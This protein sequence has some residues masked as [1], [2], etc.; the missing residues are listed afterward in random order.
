MRHATSLLAAGIALAGSFLSQSASGQVTSILYTLPAFT[1]VL[2]VQKSDNALTVFQDRLDI[3]LRS[4]F[5]AFFSDQL[6]TEDFSY[7]T[8]VDV[9]LVSQTFW[10]EINDDGETVE[11]SATTAT[12]DPTAPRRYEVRASFESQMEVIMDMDI[13]STK[14]PQ[15]SMDLLFVEALQGDNYWDL[16]ELFVSD[17]EL[18]QINTVEISVMANGFRPFDSQDGSVTGYDTE[19]YWTP[20][21]TVGVAFAVFFVCVLAIM[22]LYLCIFVRG[23]C[24]FRTRR[25]LD[26]H[27]MMDHK[28][29]PEQSSDTDQNSSD[30]EGDLAFGAGPASESAWMDA[31]ATA[32]T[33]IPVRELA[34]G[35]KKRPKK[36]RVRRPSKQ[37]C[38]NL[39]QIVELVDEDDRSL[40][41]TGCGDLE[42]CT[43]IVVYQP[44]SS[45]AARET[46]EV[47][48]EQPTSVEEE[49]MEVEYQP[50]TTTS[51]DIVA[52]K[53]SGPAHYVY[54]ARLTI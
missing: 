16:Y 24:L 50:T 43:S 31:W 39:G 12:L 48:Y 32:I 4:H 22:W 34:K 44:S 35:G 38:S 27:K 9:G 23:T 53:R 40:V 29:E 25:V 47:V 3:A 1:M 13:A 54:D 41:S 30:T 46:V 8:V 15:S 11:T 19:D 36:Q 45:Y 18:N 21:M 7:G 10:R 17:N 28:K 2:Q 52:Y 42:N 49:T 26:G 51:Q 20:S 37:N 33:S 5:I 6:N 14:L